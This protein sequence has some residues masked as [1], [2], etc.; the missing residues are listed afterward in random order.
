MHIKDVKDRG[1]LPQAIF[2]NSTCWNTEEVKTLL[3]TTII[4]LLCVPGDKSGQETT[5]GRHSLLQE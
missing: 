4:D 3:A 1:G 5:L 2:I